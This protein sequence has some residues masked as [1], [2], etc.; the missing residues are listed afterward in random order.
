MAHWKRALAVWEQLK[1]LNF[2]ETRHFEDRCRK[3]KDA[4]NLHEKQLMLGEILLCGWAR[5]P[6]NQFYLASF[7]L[8]H[9]LSRTS[10]YL[11]QF[12]LSL[13]I[14]SSLI[15]SLSQTLSISNKFLGPL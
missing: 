4:A 3:L 12:S 10:L 1:L 8:E 5:K 13:S 7:Y 15:F 2:V 14:D 6:E 9:P 11:E